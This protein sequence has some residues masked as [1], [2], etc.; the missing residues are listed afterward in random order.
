MER[1]DY[2][3]ILPDGMKAYLSLYGHHFSKKMCE[4]AVGNMKDRN[5]NRVQMRTREQV[6]NLLRARGIELKNNKGYDAVFAFH[7]CISDYLGSSVSDEV[8]AL[9]YVKDTLDDRDG[10]DGIVFDRFIADC[11]GK[12]EPII[13][14]DMI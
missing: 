14:A 13:W 10:Y 9:L 2:Y 12:G 8:H 4:W 5:G 6:E 7:M 1:M 3:D 11:N